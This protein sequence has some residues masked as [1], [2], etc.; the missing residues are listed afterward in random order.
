MKQISRC[1]TGSLSAP[2]QRHSHPTRRGTS[3]QSS[4]E[5]DLH[6]AYHSSSQAHGVDQHSRPIRQH[7]LSSSPCAVQPYDPTH[8][9]WQSGRRVQVQFPDPAH[10]AI[11]QIPQTG[12]AYLRRCPSG[13]C[14]SGYTHVVAPRSPW[15][16]VRPS[17][18]QTI[19]RQE[20]EAYQPCLYQKVHEP[21]RRYSPAW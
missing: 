7:W 8:L 1:H 11:H 9:V 17:R 20:I 19:P 5:T 6:H 3:G 15:H 21:I 2:I 10:Q 18:L 13:A 14:H 4:S 12:P 16:V